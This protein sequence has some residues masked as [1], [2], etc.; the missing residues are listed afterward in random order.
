MDDT[1]RLD[2]LLG[3]PGASCEMSIGVG[4]AVEYCYIAWFQE[5]YH[6]IV[7]GKDFRECIDNALT[8]KEEKWM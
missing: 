6:Y 7:R 3:H 2:W 4:G 8:G 5:G 1:K